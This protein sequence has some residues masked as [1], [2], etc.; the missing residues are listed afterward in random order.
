MAMALSFDPKGILRLHQLANK[1]YGQK[2]FAIDPVE[3]D[4][5]SMDT[6]DLGGE[7]QAL[8]AA[9]NDMWQNGENTDMLVDNVVNPGYNSAFQA[10]VSE[11]VYEDPLV[12]EQM[13]NNSVFGSEQP[14]RVNQFLI[15]QA[16]R[17]GV[18]EEDQANWIQNLM[19]YSKTVRG[20]ES[21]NNP[22]ASAGTTSARGVYQF[23]ADSVDTGMN[24]MRRMGFDDDYVGSI[25]PNPHEWS[26]EQA[27]AMFFGNM[28]AQTGSDEYMHGIGA[29]EQVGKDAYYKFHHT[30]PDI[31]TMKRATDFF[32]Y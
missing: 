4:D 2:G 8:E 19:D 1:K 22:M 24:R 30:A 6:E 25:S 13:T 14:S 11:E 9:L 10:P 18:P 26:D 12:K 23:T 21:D 28:F 27:D 32:G 15:K 20:I 17:L 29:G 7:K 16:N 3:K 31:N 5:I